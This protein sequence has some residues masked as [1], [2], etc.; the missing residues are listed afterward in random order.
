M[1]SEH[2]VKR[3]L[4]LWCALIA[5]VSL[6]P[7]AADAPDVDLP[8]WL[9]GLLQ[10]LSAG[11]HFLIAIVHEPGHAL[12]HW[13]FGEPALPLLTPEKGGGVTYNVGRSTALTI[14]VYALMISVLGL[15][16]RKKLWRRAAG[17]ACFIILHA[18]LVLT[19]WDRFVSMMMGHG[20]EMMAGSVL[21]ALGWKR[22]DILKTTAARGAALVAGFHLFARNI[23]LYENVLLGQAIERGVPGLTD[24]RHAAGLVDISV[25]AV[26]GG[27]IVFMLICITATACYIAL[28]ARRGKNQ[29]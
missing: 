28:S 14:F 12:T 3:N 29:T 8:V 9:R 18:L 23:L 10:S 4:P 13:L 7:Y 27:M 15:L 17:L 20:A 6:V 24:Y 1:L 26:V 19:G 16:L 21:V 2:R 25:Q 22:D 11:L 5:V